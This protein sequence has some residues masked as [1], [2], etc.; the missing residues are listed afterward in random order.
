MAMVGDTWRVITYGKFQVYMPYA[1]HYFITM[2]T[3]VLAKHMGHCNQSI[4][5][6]DSKVTLMFMR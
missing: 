3:H 2:T 6:V 4:K 1:P 5:G